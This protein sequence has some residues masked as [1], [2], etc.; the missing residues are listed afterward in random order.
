MMSLIF[1][2]YDG[3]LHPVYPRCELANEEN[4]LF[5]YLPR[6][7]SVLRDFPECKIVISSSWRENRQFEYITK[8]F[9]ADIVTRIIGVTPA[10]RSKE[11]PYPKYSRY[12][13]VLAFLDQNN[14]MA[15]RW[16]ALDDDDKIYPPEC[17]NLILCNDGFHDA[18]ENNLRNFLILSE[19]AK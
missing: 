11:P 6:L 10:L 2:D 19:A 4:Q 15:M 3:E 12:L 9:S 7:E 1:L 17:L 14:L 5:S 13:E 16:S 18:E 8:D